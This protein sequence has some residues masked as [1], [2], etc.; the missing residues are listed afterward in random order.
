MF[1]L[2]EAR[3]CRQQATGPETAAQALASVCFPTFAAPFSLLGLL[4]C[5]SW[6]THRPT[7]ETSHLLPLVAVFVPKRKLRPE[8][9]AVWPRDGRV[10]G[11][12]R[13]HIKPVQIHD[14]SVL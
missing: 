7:Y 11:I 5:P 8:I 13:Q 3:R 12:N 9:S 1:S 14:R 6:K 4:Q 2:C 10:T